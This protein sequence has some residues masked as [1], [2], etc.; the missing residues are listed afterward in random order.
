MIFK[1]FG[2]TQSVK[3]N[4]QTKKTSKK[5]NKTNSLPVSFFLLEKASYKALVSVSGLMLSP[6]PFFLCAT[7]RTKVKSYFERP[8]SNFPS[9]GGTI[10]LSKHEEQSSLSALVLYLVDKLYSGVNN[11]A[12]RSDHELLTIL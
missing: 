3:T 10:L 12:L 6:F 1:L 7:F 5:Q 8:L 11:S 9:L 4:K 2:E